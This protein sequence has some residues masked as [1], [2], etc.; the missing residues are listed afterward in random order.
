LFNPLTFTVEQEEMMVEAT[1]P[2]NLIYYLKLNNEFLIRLSGK[3]AS[4]IISSCSTV[5][6]KGTCT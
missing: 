5:K 6:V 3:V 2:D 4:T 1:F